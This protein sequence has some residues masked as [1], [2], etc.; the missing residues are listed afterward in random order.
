VKAKGDS[1]GDFEEPGLSRVDRPT[2]GD[3]MDAPLDLKMFV[4]PNRERGQPERH[5]SQ[6]AREVCHA[7]EKAQA[8]YAQIKARR[9]KGGA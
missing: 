2:F 9:Q 1:S 6:A 5:S 3:R 4:G 7:R 8:V